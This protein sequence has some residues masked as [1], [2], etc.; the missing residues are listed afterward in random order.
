M[1]N[2]INVNINGLFVLSYD[3]GVHLSEV[4][5]DYKKVTGNCVVGA[6]VDNLIIDNDSRFFSNTRVDFF[7][8]TDPEGNKMYQAGLKFLT[9][10][11]AKLVWKCDLSFKY[12]LDKGIYAEVDKKITD[13]DVEE[14]KFKIREIVGDDYPIKKCVTKREDAMTYYESTMESEKADNVQNIPNKY[15]ELY[16]VNHTYNFFYDMM[17]ASTSELGL[18][19]IVRVDK[20]GIVL[21][22][23]RIDEG[24]KLPTF[25]FNDKIYKELL[26]R[27]KWARQMGVSYVNNINSIVSK[28]DI[29]KF[30]KMDNIFMD[31]SLYGIAKD[32]AKKRKNLKMILIGGP[33]SSGKTTSAH[34]LCTYLETFGVKPIVISAD[35]YFKERC[36]NP[37]DADGN[38]DFECLE[39]IDIPLF[40]DHLKRLIDGEEVVIPKFDF[41]VGTKEY[42]RK[43]IRLEEDNILL[44]EGIHCLN[45]KLTK[46]IKRD[47]K[48]K[49][50]VCPF[51]PLGLD[52]HNHLS[53]TDMRIVRRMVRDNRKRGRSVELTLRDWRKVKAGEDKYIFPYTDD[54][55]AVLNTAYTYELGVLRVFAEP[56]LYSVGIDS[57]YYDEARR[58]LGL[59]RMFYPIS[60]EHIEN[61]NIIREFIGGSI[62]ED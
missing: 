2:K 54:I 49:I 51:T 9:I 40:N 7:D 16:E 55:D 18:F 33:S 31:D 43:P 35:D 41:V 48:Y 8:Y 46:S 15:V 60:S 6:R 13:E 30:I 59:L 28:G 38:Y 52:R 34:K 50:F 29:Q 58:M 4:I 25:T 20:N 56:L 11:A 26:R 57:E 19:D 14:L 37:K 61:D 1:G 12:S 44:I 10:L 22:Y 21:L 39:A 42:S 62:Y 5:H 53:T 23:P 24:G 32:I 27:N 17:P 45:E 3:E 36:D 47:Y